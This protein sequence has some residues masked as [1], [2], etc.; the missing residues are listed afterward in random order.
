[1]NVI[2]FGISCN[3]TKCRTNELPWILLSASAVL[4]NINHFNFFA[5][6]GLRG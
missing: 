4:I 6:K 1:M 2:H 5:V 3:M